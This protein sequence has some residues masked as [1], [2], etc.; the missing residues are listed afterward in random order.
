MA[1]QPDD[2]HDDA[3]A[4][5]RLGST[6]AARQLKYSLL[7]SVF[8]GLLIVAFRGYHDYQWL[9][10]I[11]QQANQ[12][13]TTS[14]VPVAVQ[15]LLRHDRELAEV[16]VRGMLNQRSI[17]SVMLTTAEDGIFFEQRRAA[18]EIPS[19][20]WAETMFGGL[21]TIVIPV[22][23]PH[24]KPVTTI[25]EMV[26]EFNPQ[27]YVSAFTSRLSWSLLATMVM[28]VS[29]AFL[30]AGM[31]YY[32]FSRPL[33]R[34]G[35][36][37][38]KSDPTDESRPLEMP[39]HHRHDDEIQLLGSV[40]V[41]LFGM[42]RGQLG[43]LRKA[44]DEL[45][46][47][48]VNLEARV[49]A[50]TDEL[51][52]A[53]QKL[54]VLASTD[55]LTGLPNRRSY[56]ARFDE[57][58]SVWRRRDT[59]VSIILL[60]I[61]RFKAFNDTYGHQAGDA[62]LVELGRIMRATLREIDLPA[63]MGGEEFAVLL[64]GEELAGALKLAERLRVAFE[65]A[66]VSFGGSVLSFT[67]SFGIAGLPSEGQLK[68]FDKDASAHIEAMK[69]WET[70]DISNLMYSMVDSALYQAKEKGRNR[71]EQCDY[72]QLPEH[73]NAFPFDA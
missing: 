5:L 66:S 53:M 12:R 28:A 37:L 54:E 69:S 4:S 18:G 23:D 62:V 35:S 24:Q 14:N 50:R 25:G 27:V 20:R 56:L 48:N 47:A 72:T 73:S 17:Q 13:V 59:P 67:A 42:I 3:L 68:T 6:I 38:I 30:F 1:K 15:V 21:Q 61:D 58:I 51:K 43:Q 32:I 11:Y 52:E 45:M 70:G 8:L 19:S 65:R 33:V 9:K 26:I 10:E 64:P 49:A 22:R 60:D 41:G 55:P 40:T 34:L 57:A 16:M 39:P 46:D 36:Y 63:R 7:L 31:S 2:K 44:R 71:C 29:M